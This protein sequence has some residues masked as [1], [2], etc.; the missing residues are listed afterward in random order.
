MATEKNEIE[1]GDEPKLLEHLDSSDNQKSEV[2]I[3]TIYYL[4]QCY[5]RSFKLSIE[6]SL[7]E[8]RPIVTE[9]YEI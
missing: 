3:K 8:I 1:Y 5:C 9:I 6:T 4:I 7:D 2:R